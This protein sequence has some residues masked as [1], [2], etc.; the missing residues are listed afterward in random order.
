[1]TNTLHRW[2]DYKAARQYIRRNAMIGRVRHW[3]PH[4]ISGLDKIYPKTGLSFAIPG[5]GSNWN[6]HGKSAIR[7]TVD[8][9]RLDNHIVDIDGQ[10]IFEFSDIYDARYEMPGLNLFKRRI[11]VIE[12]CRAKQD[13]A[14]VIGNIRGLSDKLLAIEIGCEVDSK[15][16][17]KVG[18]YARMNDIP[19]EDD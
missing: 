7:F 15:T 11:E 1:M 12:R 8:R 5:G 9:A 3:L 17:E 14:F 16:R 4:E 13:E 19:L 2:V 6:A 18:D 10:A